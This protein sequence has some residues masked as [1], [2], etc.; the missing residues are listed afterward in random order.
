VATSYNNLGSAYWALGQF[1]EALSYYQQAL[2]I[3]L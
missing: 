3:F 1:K 2:A